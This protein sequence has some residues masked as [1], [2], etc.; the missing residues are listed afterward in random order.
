VNL[1]PLREAVIERLKHAFTEG[2]LEV[3]ELEERLERAGAASETTQLR[4]LVA[5]LPL[6]AST[7]PGPRGRRTFLTILGGVTKAGRWQPPERIRAFTVM[8]GTELD[9]READWP[10]AGTTIDVFC[11]MGG[12][13]ITVAPDVT[14]EVDGAAIMG[15]FEDQSSSDPGA[16]PMLRVRGFGLM[17][18]VEVRVKSRNT[19]R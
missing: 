15:A 12:V 10:P 17:G 9:F 3:E 4:A 11:V 13:E 6:A 2:L 14:V 7:P 8:G 18:G 19:E 1:Q 5:D 16:A